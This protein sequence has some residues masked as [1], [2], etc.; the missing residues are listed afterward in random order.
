MSLRSR[1]YKPAIRA[2]LKALGWLLLFAVVPSAIYT[3][4]QGFR[5]GASVFLVFGLTAASALLWAFW[6]VLFPK[7]IGGN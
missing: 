1:F 5:V 7:D 3:Y 4:T 6:G 2:Y